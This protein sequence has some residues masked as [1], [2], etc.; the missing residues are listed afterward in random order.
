MQSLD[1]SDD[2]TLYIRTWWSN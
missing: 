2:V 1:I